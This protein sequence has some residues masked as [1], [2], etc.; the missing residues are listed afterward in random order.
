MSI[1][2]SIP[3]ARSQPARPPRARPPKSNPS[4]PSPAQPGQPADMRTDREAKGVCVCGLAGLVGWT[5][6]GWVHAFIFFDAVTDTDCLMLPAAA[7]GLGGRACDDYVWNR[8]DGRDGLVGHFSH[9]YNTMADQHPSYL[10]YLTCLTIT[11]EP[12]SLASHPHIAAATMY[13]LRLRLRLVPS[14]Y[15][16]HRTC[17]PALPDLPPPSPAA[18]GNVLD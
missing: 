7:A 2:P 10:P 8:S 5:V 4:Q 6:L 12:S 9:T 17:L 16:S 11:F 13:R 15:T 1:H 14:N 3:R 18:S